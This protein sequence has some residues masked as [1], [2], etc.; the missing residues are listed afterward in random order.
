MFTHSSWTDVRTGSYERLAFLGDSVLGL[1]VSTELYPRFADATAGDLTK[2]RAQ[3]VSGTACARVAVEMGVPERLTTLAPIDPEIRLDELLAAQRVLA[4]I[5]ESIIGACYLQ[6]GYEDT[7]V[8][9]VEAFAREIDE[10]FE[11]PGDF[12]SRLQ[13]RLAR[14]GEKPL[15]VLVSS[16]G[17]PHDVRFV[18]AVEIRGDRYGTGNGRSKKEA[19]QAAAGAALA[20]LDEEHLGS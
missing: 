17:P 7:A 15:Y 12:K 14:S 8:A 3:A 20:R 16:E 19:E 10:A 4:S 11:H 13:E 18:C 9:V 1:A 6:Y 5:C 2:I